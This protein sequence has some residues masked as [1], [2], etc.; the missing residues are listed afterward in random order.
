MSDS[1]KLN[2][3]YVSS[4][5]MRALEAVRPERTRLFDDPF[6]VR[7]LPALLRV[8]LLPGPRHLLVAVMESR[9][10]G[11]LGMLFCRMRYTDDVLRRRLGKGVEQVVILGAGFDGRAF[12]IPGIERTQVFE[13]DLP[14]PQR[15]KQDYLR[16]R[17]GALPS[18]LTFVPID[19]NTQ[20]LE[21]ALPAAG[22]RE[23]TSTF[24]IAEG[25]TQYITAE[26]VDGILRFV[27][28]HTGT[29]SQ[30][31]FTYIQRAI[32]DGSARSELDRKFVALTQREGIPWV[33]GFDPTELEAHLARQ[34]LALIEDVDAAEYRTRYLEPLGRRMDV[35]AGE[36]IVLAE[37]M[38]HQLPH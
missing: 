21:E 11:A 3:G 35:Y 27:A 8:F 38:S 24:F 17:F 34:G 7:A 30:I 26:A 1:R 22:F 15:F 31:A 14:D 32:V 4:A 37:A 23:G 18:H 6:S 9:V 28:R 33:T 2:L 13:L 19:L 12:R 10:P 20:K 5:F 25:V 29:G 16:R 36:R